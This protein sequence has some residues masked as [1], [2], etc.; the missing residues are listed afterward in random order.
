LRLTDLGRELL[1]L[2]GPPDG[3]SILLALSS[4]VLLAVSAVTLYS[5]WLVGVPVSLALA[6]TAIVL[7]HRVLAASEVV[8]TEPDAF[9]RMLLEAE[10]R[11]V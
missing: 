4:L 5:S 8:D 7:V 10:L 9:E 6:T 2:D 1:P 11:E 3:A